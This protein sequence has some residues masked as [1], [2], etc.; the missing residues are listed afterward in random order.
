MDQ[1]DSTSTEPQLPRQPIPAVVDSFA[2]K[3]A[4]RARRFQRRFTRQNVVSFLK[5]LAWVVP[6]TLLIWIYAEQEQLVTAT[7]VPAT[8]DVQSTDPGRTVTLLSPR[9]KMILCDLRG[10]NSILD[11]IRDRRVEEDLGGL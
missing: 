2:R 5:T 6:L 1:P 4:E 10:P 7:N 3:A 11:R 9:E 8:I